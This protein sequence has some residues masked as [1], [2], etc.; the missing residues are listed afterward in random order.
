M[1][2]RYSTLA[3]RTVCL[4]LALLCITAGCSG[5]GPQTITITASPTPASPDGMASPSTAADVPSNTTEAPTVP[6]PV[7]TANDQTPEPAEPLQTPATDPAEDVSA[8]AFR[9]EDVPP[10][11]GAAYAAVNGNVPFFEP[12]QITNVGTERYSRFD[13]LGRCGP[14]WASVGLELMPQTDRGDISSVTP[15]GWNQAKVDGEWLY[16]RCHLIGYQLTA[17]DARPQNLITG[18]RYLNIQ[19][20]LPFENMVAD[21]VKETGNHVM[22]RATPVFVGDE[23]VCRGVLLEGLSVEDEG[24]GICFCVF[25]YN[26]QPGLELNYADGSI[27][28]TSLPVGDGTIQVQPTAELVPDQPAAPITASYVGNKN[29]RKFHVSSCSSVADMK[30]SN[31]VPLASRE[32]AIAEGYEPCKRCNP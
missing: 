6:M 20:M 30:E 11:S 27:I 8:A 25:A 10:F 19:G 1:K 32:E 4:L 23:L 17:E 3:K 29:T 28:A 31:K 7:Q 21:Y 13:S 18:T 12:S 15:S 22:Y 2:T 5:P 14:A 16:N 26:V 24:D 9:Y